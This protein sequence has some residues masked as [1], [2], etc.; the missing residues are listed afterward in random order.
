MKKIIDWLKDNEIGQGTMEYGW[1]LVIISV[2]FI[3]LLTALG[4]TLYDK[5]ISIENSMP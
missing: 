1:I 2:A 3:L 5:Y 4:T